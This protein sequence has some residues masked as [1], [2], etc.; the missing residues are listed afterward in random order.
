MDAVGEPETDA[1]KEAAVLP[2]ALGVHVPLLV[3]DP[4]AV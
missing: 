2:V 1:L 3:C 4:V